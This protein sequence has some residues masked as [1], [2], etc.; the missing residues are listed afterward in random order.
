M[1]NDAKADLLAPLVRLR[2]VRAPDMC[3]MIAN[4]PLCAGRDPFA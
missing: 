4:S 1:P 3:E 2:L